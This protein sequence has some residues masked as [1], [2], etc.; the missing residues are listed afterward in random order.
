MRK[1]IYTPEHAYLVSQLRKARQQAKLTQKQVAVTLGVTQSFISK[2][3]SG[4]YRVDTVQLKELGK[5]YRK[6][7]SF[8]L[9]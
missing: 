3:E 4:Q 1:T 5:L 2:V 8:F 9:R 6:P 7:I